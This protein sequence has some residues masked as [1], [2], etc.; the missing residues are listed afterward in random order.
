VVAPELTSVGKCGPKLQLMW[1]RVDAHLAPYL[2]LEPI[3]GGTWS[4]GYRQRPPGPTSGEAVN[5]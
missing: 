2:N 4:L 1:Q 5:P 3:C